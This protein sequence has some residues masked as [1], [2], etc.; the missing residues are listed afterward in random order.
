MIIRLVQTH[1]VGSECLKWHMHGRC[2]DRHEPSHASPVL[3][4]IETITLV[5]SHPSA[6][7]TTPYFVRYHE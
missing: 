1:H 6:P 4:E 3:M 5:A 7:P 2:G